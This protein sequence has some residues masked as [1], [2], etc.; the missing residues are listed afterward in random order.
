MSAIRGIT[1]GIALIAIGMCIVHVG[2]AAFHL[3]SPSAPE[4]IPCKCAKCE[5][6]K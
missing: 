6:A 1:F 2:N 5:A 4:S 3:L